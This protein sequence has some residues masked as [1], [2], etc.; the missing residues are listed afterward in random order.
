PRGLLVRGWLGGQTGTWLSRQFGRATSSTRYHRTADGEFLF[1]RNIEGH[2]RGALTLAD[3][4]DHVSL[5]LAQLAVGDNQAVAATAGGA[6]KRHVGKAVAEGAQFRHRGGLCRNQ[7][8]G[9]CAQ[10]IQKQRS[11]CFQNVCLAGAVLTIITPCFF[12]LDQLK[13]RPEEAEEMFVQRNRQA[14]S[15]ASRMSGVKNCVGMFSAKIAPLT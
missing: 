3:S 11:D 2:V 6:A 8:V 12:G 14:L 5:D 4:D 7:T 13:H 15:S 10:F 9:F 1:Q